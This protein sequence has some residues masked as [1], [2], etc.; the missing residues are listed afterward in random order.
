[1]TD[2]WKV[3]AGNLLGIEKMAIASDV[4]RIYNFD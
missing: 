2:M 1:M 4:I 3:Q